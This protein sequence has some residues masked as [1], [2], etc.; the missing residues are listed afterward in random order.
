MNQISNSLTT[1]IKPA[2]TLFNDNLNTLITGVFASIENTI[3]LSEVETVVDSYLNKNEVKALLS[4]MEK[5]YVL[6]KDTYKY[7]TFSISFK[8][9]G[10]LSIIL[11]I[12]FSPLLNIS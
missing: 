5:D 2:K 6:P 10:I 12:I 3:S 9:K 7:L 4:K 8:L 1:D 11:L